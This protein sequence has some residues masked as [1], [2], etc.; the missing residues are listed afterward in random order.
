VPHIR[1]LLGR[2]SGGKGRVVL[3]PSLGHTQSVEIALA[4]GFHVTPRLAEALKVV[5]GVRRVEEI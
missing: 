1:D 4:G 5:P 2:E 3:V